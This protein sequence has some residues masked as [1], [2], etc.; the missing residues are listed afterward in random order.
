MMTLR[1]LV[2]FVLLLTVPFQAAVGATGYVCGHGAHHA[3]AS[4]GASRDNSPSLEHPHDRAFEG[5]GASSHGSHHGDGHVSLAGA[6]DAVG[7]DALTD[8]DASDDNVAG[9]CQFCS[10]CSFS[11][12]PASAF[13]PNAATHASPL[14]VSFYVDPAI[15]PH[16]G[17]ALFRPPRSVRS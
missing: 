17:N 2:L 15:L 3:G 6:A 5:H 12:A 16:V 1:R 11:L 7:Q 9:T 8:S 14:R 13:S 10:E 4:A